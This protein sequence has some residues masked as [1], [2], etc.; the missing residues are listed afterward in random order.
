MSWKGVKKTPPL[1]KI[2][3]DLWFFLSF[4][5]QSELLHL[6]ENSGTWIMSFIA[7]CITCPVCS[8]VFEQETMTT[9]HQQLDKQS[10]PS[11]QHRCQPCPYPE[12]LGYQ[13][14]P[15][16][17]KFEFR[18]SIQHLYTKETKEFSGRYR[19]KHTQITNI[20]YIP[21]YICID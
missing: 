9:S 10:S 16:S 15:K 5:L 17:L 21:K 1:P 19:K 8:S 13:T 4:H 14:I 6:L 11:R 18:V 2:L 12:H 3:K 7:T 20:I